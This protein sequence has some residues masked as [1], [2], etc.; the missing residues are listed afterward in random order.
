MNHLKSRKLEIYP[1][2]KK[3]S[4]YI[5]MDLIVILVAFIAISIY[6]IDNALQLGQSDSDFALTQAIY[7]TV[8]MMMLSGMQVIDTEIIYK[9]SLYICLRG[10]VI[11]FLLSISP[12]SLARPANN[13]KSWL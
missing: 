11:V 7:Y 13:A 2:S 10:W 9:A 3:Q 5:Q 8:G 4:H 12:T 6:E 1:M